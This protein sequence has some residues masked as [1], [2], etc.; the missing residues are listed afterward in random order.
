MPKVRFAKAQWDDHKT[1]MGEDSW[2]V[3]QV[4]QAVE[5]S[6]VL[7]ISQEDLDLIGRGCLH[8]CSNGYEKH[9][10]MGEDG[11]LFIISN[12]VLNIDLDLLKQEATR[13]LAKRK[14][15]EEEDEKWS[16]EHERKAKKEIVQKVLND[17]ELRQEVIEALYHE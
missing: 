17:P 10:K 16:Q 12:D 1:W 6:D 4:V 14:E 2:E 5:V 9:F 13:R 15:R 8:L 7:E 11:E 3:D